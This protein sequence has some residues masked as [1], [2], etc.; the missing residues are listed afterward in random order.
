MAARSLL[1]GTA[2]AIRRPFSLTSSLIPASGAG[3]M[4][5]MARKPKAYSYLRFSS[6]RQADGDSI[7]RQTDAAARYASTHGLTLDTS[8]T[9]RDLGVSAFEGKNIREG[10]ALHAFLEAVEN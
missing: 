4:P 10:G 8:L 9:F 5:A 7:R 3:K 6:A 1:N 2:G